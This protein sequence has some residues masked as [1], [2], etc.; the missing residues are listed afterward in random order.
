MGCQQEI[1]QSLSVK[2]I[3]KGKMG[4]TFGTCLLKALHVQSALPLLWCTSNMELSAVFPAGYYIQNLIT[5]WWLLYLL[6]HP[7]RPPSYVM[8]F[9]A[10]FRRNIQRQFICVLGNGS[11]KVD[12]ITRNNCRSCRMERY[13]N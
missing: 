3:K 10:F 5:I 12:Q 1:Y 4:K 11:C 13:G 6:Y 8:I 2:I 9:R 7:N